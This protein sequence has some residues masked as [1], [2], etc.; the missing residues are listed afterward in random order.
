M[1]LSQQKFREVVLQLLFSADFDVST[2]VEMLPF[3][4]SEFAVS[5]KGIREAQSRKQEIVAKFPEID[6]RLIQSM[7]D[8]Q[9]DR[10]PRLEHAILRL[11]TYE[12]LFSDLPPK[13]AIAEALRLARKY[14]TDEAVAFVNAV[15]DSIYKTCTMQVTSS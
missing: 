1:A 6:E 15:L 12:L 9:L 4:M 11:G 7:K 5:K 2:D 8:Y 10:V 13:V 14:A 3:M